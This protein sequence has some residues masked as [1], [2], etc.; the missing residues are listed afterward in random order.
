MLVAAGLAA[1]AMTAHCKST[2]VNNTGDL[3][4]GKAYQ[5][6]GQALKRCKAD[7]SG[8]EA[9]PFLTCAPGVRCDDVAG[10]CLGATVDG[11]DGNTCVFD[12]PNSKFDECTFAP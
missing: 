4:G 10:V 8:F 6:D 7:Q 9:S 5:C 12:D 2:I 1:C 3:C 11:G